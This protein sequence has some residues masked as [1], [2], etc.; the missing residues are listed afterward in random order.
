MRIVLRKGPHAHEPVQGAGRL[1]AMHL[2]EF[3]KTQRQ[4]AIAAQTLLEHLDMTRAIHRLDRE[5]VARPASGS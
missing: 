5:Q 2:A 3:R 1:V 4:L